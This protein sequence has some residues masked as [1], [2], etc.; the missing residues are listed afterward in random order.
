MLSEK[1]LNLLEKIV[2]KEIT[3]MNNE[4]KTGFS[5]KK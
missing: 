5:N 4:A 3:E 2:N 1:Q